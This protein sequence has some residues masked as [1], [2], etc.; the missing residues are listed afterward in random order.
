MTENKTTASMIRYFRGILM[1]KT[2]KP[3][4]YEFYQGYRIRVRCE[5]GGEFVNVRNAR[6]GNPAI[7]ACA[8]CAKQKA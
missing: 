1:K 8:D 5:C 2:K 7:W 6:C 3:D 4:E